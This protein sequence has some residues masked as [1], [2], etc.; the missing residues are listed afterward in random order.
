MGSSS[1][2]QGLVTKK[3]IP[4]SK[5]F[6]LPYSGNFDSYADQATVKYFTDE[7]GSWNAAPCAMGR[8]GMCLMQVVT[9]YPI[10]WEKNPDPFTLL[11]DSQSSEWAD[12]TV[13][14]DS[15]EG[16]APKGTSQFTK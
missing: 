5:V 3:D 11:G 2:G 16:V 10:A 15:L 6:P 8:K 9:R 14:T 4:A 7:G 13:S 12:Y 1:T